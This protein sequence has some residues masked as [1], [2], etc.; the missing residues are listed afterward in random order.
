MRSGTPSRRSL[1]IG[2]QVVAEDGCH[3]VEVVLA[4]GG[5]PE[6]HLVLVGWRVVLQEHVP[7]ADGDVRSSAV[8]LE[9]G[10][11]LHREHGV[12]QRA[13]VAAVKQREVADGVHVA[14]A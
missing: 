6:M 10:G 13:V 4:I 1:L 7:G 9:Y 2:P 8:A 11:A 5:A 14:I 3:L 12:A